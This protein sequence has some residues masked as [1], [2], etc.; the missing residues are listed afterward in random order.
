MFNRN[1]SAALEIEFA[2]V[3]IDPTAFRIGMGSTQKHM[4]DGFVVAVRITT[5]TVVFD[6]L[7]TR[8]DH[9]PRSQPA[10]PRLL[11]RNAIGCHINI[12]I[13]TQIVQ[14]LIP[15][16]VK[17]IDPKDRPRHKFIA[18]TSPYARRFGKLGI[19]KQTDDIGFEF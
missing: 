7:F 2:N 14:H 1:V 10:I 18:V 9:S 15:Q 19:L 5:G 13:G 16:M 3:L 12:L 17:P 6:D 11:F 8:R 4:G